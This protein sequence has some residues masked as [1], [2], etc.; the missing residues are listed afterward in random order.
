MVVRGPYQNLIFDTSKVVLVVA[1]VV[2]VVV[3]VVVGGLVVVTQGLLK[4][5]TCNA[6]LHTKFPPGV[7]GPAE[8]TN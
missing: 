7:D 3:V 4:Q 5:H 1:V 6:F 2:V 8:V